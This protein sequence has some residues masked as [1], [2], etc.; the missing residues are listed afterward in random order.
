[1][2]NLSCSSCQYATLRFNGGN[3]A[4]TCERLRGR[5]VATGTKLPTRR[6]EL[7]PLEDDQGSAQTQ[8]DRPSRS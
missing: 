5:I 8:A 2:T 1:M 6:P 4:T 3:G 7:C